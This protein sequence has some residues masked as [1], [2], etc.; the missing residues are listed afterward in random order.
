MSCNN[1]KTRNASRVGLTSCFFIALQFRTEEI[2]ITK[3]LIQYNISKVKKEGVQASYSL[4]YRY[5]K[6]V[7]RFGASFDVKGIA[8]LRQ[9]PTYDFVI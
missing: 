8:P 5:Y 7:S 4:R 9:P 3:T 6:G 1:F 2:N